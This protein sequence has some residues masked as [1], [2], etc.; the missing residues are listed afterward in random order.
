V[1]ATGEVR[2]V[3]CN[4]SNSID[5]RL[6]AT[7]SKPLPEGFD[8][9][10]PS[11]CGNG[12]HRSAASRTKRRHPCPRPPLCPAT[13]ASRD[14]PL[15]IGEDALQVLMRYGWPGNVRQLSNVLFRAALQSEGR[16]SPPRLPAHRLQSRFTNRVGDNAG[17]IGKA[18][19]SAALPEGPRSPFGRRRAPSLA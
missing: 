8:P 3:G 4:G 15:S 1:L 17:E 7:S 11:V 13:L 16:R 9:G 19:A 5:V 14:P 12:G 6:I 18:A 2:P 10:L